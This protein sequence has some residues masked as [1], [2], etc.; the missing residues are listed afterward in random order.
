MK[1]GEKPL[2]DSLR[3]VAKH[4]AEETDAGGRFLTQLPQQLTAT[5]G[6]RVEG[7]AQKNWLHDTQLMLQMETVMMI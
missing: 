7:K 6:D 3:L 5:D 2:E 4:G 1:L